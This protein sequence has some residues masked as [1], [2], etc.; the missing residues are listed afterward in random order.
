MSAPSYPVRTVI[1][2]A[3]VP[4]DAWPRLM[5]ELP[6]LLASLAPLV[7]IYDAARDAGSKIP[8]SAY[9]DMLKTFNWVDDDLSS[10]SITVTARDASGAEVLHSVNRFTFAPDASA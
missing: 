3:R 4:A 2:M 7:A 6:V 8:D 1:D 10:A 9:M 5:A